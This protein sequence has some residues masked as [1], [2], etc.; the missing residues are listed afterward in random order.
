MKVI[1]YKCSK[2]IK[3]IEPIAEEGTEDGICNSCLIKYFPHIAGLILGD[4]YQIDQ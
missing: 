3:E 2:E 1:C 4:E